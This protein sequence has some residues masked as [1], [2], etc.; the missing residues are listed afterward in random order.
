MYLDLLGKTG[1]NIYAIILRK[2][3][4]E[5]IKFLDCDGQNAA[6]DADGINTFI[7]HYS[8]IKGVSFR[9]WQ[10]VVIIDLILN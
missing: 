1:K 3:Y 6:K 7:S 9:K 10:P 2:S 8:G 4:T 5:W